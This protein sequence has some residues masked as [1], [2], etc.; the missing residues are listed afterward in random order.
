M[1]KIYEIHVLKG[2]WICFM[3]NYITVGVSQSTSSYS[4]EIQPAELVLVQVGDSIKAT[5]T[6]AGSLAPQNL[7]WIAVKSEQRF[8]TF[9]QLR[10]NNQT[11]ELSIPRAEPHMSG[12]YECFLR[13]S[14]GGVSTRTL[15]VIV[16]LQG[17]DVLI[18][19][20]KTSEIADVLNGD[21]LRTAC[22]QVTFFCKNVSGPISCNKLCNGIWDCPQGEDELQCR[23]I[24]KV[25]GSHCEGMFSC[26]NG[27]C[28]Y[29][30][31]VCDQVDNCG[32]N[33]DELVC[34]DYRKAVTTDAPHSDIDDDSMVWLK[35]TVY[36]VIGCT[37]SVV[38]L[39]SIV[40]IAI[41]N[42]KMKRR[43]EARALRHV[44]RRR[45]HIHQCDSRHPGA[46]SP[47][48]SHDP[49]EHQPFISTPSPPHF[50]NI[51]VNVNNGVQ[52]VPM[53][54]PSLVVPP[55]SYSEVMAEVVV[56][57]HTGR[58]SPPPE[59]S[60]L[61]RNPDRPS[62]GNASVSISQ[63]S[64]RAREYNSRRNHRD[65]AASVSHTHTHNDNQMSR[66]ENYYHRPH[67]TRH[68]THFSQ[69]QS[70]SETS[71]LGRRAARHSA[72]HARN[73][74]AVGMQRRQKQL[75]V[76][77]GQILLELD[78]VATNSPPTERLNRN[79]QTNSSDINTNCTSSARN[80]AKPGQIQVQEGQ[81]VSA[82]DSGECTSICVSKHFR[83]CPVFGGSELVS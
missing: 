48:Q 16:L 54:D 28:V 22:R 73:V 72:R 62:G 21:L 20:R 36:T 55:P 58:S 60:T 7:L 44:E 13:D 3:L 69:P 49:I 82:S 27:R 74:R 39:I 34:G 50:R 68:S 71:S 46:G 51:I 77:D 67:S 64:N 56:D 17:N 26:G 52:Y 29:N 42:I 63:S 40:V 5:C 14:K 8:G 30:D 37:V 65:N 70:V 18:N 43:A 83:A 53:A 6:A 11:V 61:D 15:Q 38:F 12:T 2:I 45:R 31:Y 66:D 59:Y 57:L 19:R 33:S 35:T 1:C 24:G 4:L 25:M 76:Q 41:F 80:E 23:Y 9:H 78:G 81:I 47:L 75:V 79:T 10:P 32:D